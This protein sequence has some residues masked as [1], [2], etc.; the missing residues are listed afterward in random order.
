MNNCDELAQTL[1]DQFSSL[2][3]FGNKMALFSYIA[4]SEEKGNYVEY[5]VFASP[6][7]TVHRW[8]LLYPEFK[9]E[10]P[11]NDYDIQE[12]SHY[13]YVM[14][15]DCYYDLMDLGGNNLNI[16]SFPDDRD[17]IIRHLHIFKGESPLVDWLLD[18]SPYDK[19]IHDVDVVTD[20]ISSLKIPINQVITPLCYD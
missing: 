8:V 14:G 9:Y 2:A 6:L 10:S 19:F 7:S 3:Q 18:V 11:I 4:Y 5:I 12:E 17:W 16:V 20:F 13:I 1:L 15:R